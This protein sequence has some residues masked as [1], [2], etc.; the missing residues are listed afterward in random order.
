MATHRQHLEKNVFYYITFTCYRWM[1]LFEMTNIFDFISISFSKL[2]AKDFKNVGFV[3][4]P[5]HMHFV[6]VAGEKSKNLNREIGNTKRFLAY[7]IV[8][9]LESA[10]E[11]EILRILHEGVAN[12]ERNI[13]KKH[14]VFR[15]SFDA[16]CIIDETELLKVLD[17]MHH[18]PIKGKWNLVDDFRHYPYSSAGFY[19]LER[20]CP[21]PLWD[22]RLFV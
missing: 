1:L 3:I 20:P 21:F 4:M 6:V 18:N 17:Y 2:A 13:G 8:D 22:Y 19:E 9:R 7:E 12:K 16:Q 14:H 10:G 15:G 5:N 11:T